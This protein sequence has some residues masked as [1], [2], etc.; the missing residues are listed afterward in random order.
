MT[1]PYPVPSSLGNTQKAAAPDPAGTVN[2][3]TPCKITGSPSHSLKVTEVLKTLVF[4]LIVTLLNPICLL[5]SNVK[6][7]NHRLLPAQKDAQGERKG[8]KSSK[9]GCIY[10]RGD[11]RGTHFSLSRRKMLP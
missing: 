4:T 8:R 1:P 2:Y 5:L 6:S 3:F 9:S 7:E 11:N 10:V